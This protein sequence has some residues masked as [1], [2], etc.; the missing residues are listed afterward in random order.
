MD[1][2]NKNSKTTQ[3]TFDLNQYNDELEW[4]PKFKEVESYNDKYTKKNNNNYYGKEFKNKYSKQNNDNN[5]LDDRSSNYYEYR[6]EY[7]NQPIYNNYSNYYINYQNDYRNYKGYDDNNFNENNYSKYNTKSNR[8]FNKKEVKL[9]HFINLPIKDEEFCKNYKIFKDELEKLGID[10]KLIQPIIKLH[11]TVCVLSLNQNQVDKVRT[12]LDNLLKS[13]FNDFKK[14]S[15]KIDS[16]TPMNENSYKNRVIFGDVKKNEKYEN[17]KEIF[18]LII[19]S[20]VKNNIMNDESLK[21]SHIE[22]INGKY[23]NIV[24]LT[25]LNTKF[26]KNSYVRCIENGQNIL[27]ALNTSKFINLLPDFPLD[28]IDFCQFRIDYNTG[29]YPVESTHFLI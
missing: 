1:K 11:F 21:E 29:T 25:I 23:T 8:N 12:I 6:K 19:D 28:R 3:N 13:N 5:Y 7:Y 10:Q 9:T 4:G 2:K 15:L 16:F 22:K 27:S 26:L 18:H 14:F 20:L 17:I 24:H